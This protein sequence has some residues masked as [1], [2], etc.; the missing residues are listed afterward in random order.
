MKQKRNGKGGIFELEWVTKGT[1]LLFFNYFTI[2][3]F[4]T[5]AYKLIFFFLITE[6]FVAA[7]LGVIWINPQVYTIAYKLRI[8]GKWSLQ[9]CAV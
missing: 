8:I 1:Q 3:E 4:L 6:K 7:V 2:G 9:Y 5:F